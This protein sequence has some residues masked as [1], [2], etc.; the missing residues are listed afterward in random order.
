MGVNDPPPAAEGTDMD[1]P[2]VSI[3][4]E[5]DGPWVLVSWKAWA[6]A[7]EYR[8]AHEVILGAIRK[9]HASRL[10]IDAR[11][12][13]VIAAADQQWLKADWIP[14]AIAAGRRWTAVVMPASPLVKTIV[15]S[16]DKDVG[17]NTVE[18]RYFDTTDQ[19]R[20]WLS[21]VG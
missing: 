20:A 11:N 14:R 4:W 9:H 13:K 2:Y 5:G 15:E 19:A 21:T 3:R 17:K 1:A 7:T 6:N 8:A 18:T 10:L 16:I 12:A